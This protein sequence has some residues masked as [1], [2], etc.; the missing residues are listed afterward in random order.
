MMNL[1]KKQAEE[2]QKELKKHFHKEFEELHI[3][4]L[5]ELQME[6]EIQKELP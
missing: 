3:M 6:Q 1:Q 5:V 4:A 2:L